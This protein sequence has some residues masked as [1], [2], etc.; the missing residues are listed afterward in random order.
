MSSR[1]P[2][3]LVATP[4][5]APPAR[6][7][8]GRRGTRTC[9]ASGETTVYQ[10]C[11]DHPRSNAALG[12]QTMTQGNGSNGVRSYDAVIVGAGFGGHVHAPPACANLGFSAKVIE[13]RRRRRRDVVLEP[14][15]RCPLRRREPQLL[16]LVLDRSSSRSGLEREVLAAARDPR[17]TPTTWPIAS[18]SA[19]TSSSRPASTRRCGT[20][21]AAAGP[22]PRRRARR[23]SAQFYIM[24][25]GCLSHSKLPEIP[26]VE[27]FAGPDVPHRPLAARGRRLHRPARRRHR[28]RIVGHP[29]DP[30]HRRAGR[31]TDGVPAH[32]ELQHARRQPPAR[33]EPR[34]TP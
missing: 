9:G 26:G 10:F 28:H 17:R 5:L 6:P 14:L 30:G 12:G 34:S 8:A 7:P 27:S 29:V 20:T 11:E 23:I 13:R 32:T 33:P 2:L 16:V 4:A 1:L 31:P 22:S 19:R 25:S 15:S 3:S 24:A 21:S 18:T